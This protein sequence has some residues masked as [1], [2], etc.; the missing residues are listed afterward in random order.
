MSA[1]SILCEMTM[2][3][4]IAPDNELVAS[5]AKEGSEIAFQALVKRHVSLV[6]ATAFRQV[7]D[8]GMAEE[9]AQN[10]F[11]ALAQKAPRLAARE[12]LA[13]WLHRATIFEAKSRIR[14]ELRRRRHEDVVAE[15]AQLHCEKGAMTEDLLPVLDEGLLN[16][17]EGDRLALI[18]RFLDDRS[19]REVGDYFGVDEEAARKR[20]SRALD[21]LALFFQRQ[22]FAIPAGT[23]CAALMTSAA[24][25]AP[26]GLAVSI[27]QT[28]LLSGSTASG[29][30]LLLLNLMTLT[31]VQTA[32]ICLVLAATPLVLQR[33]AQAREENRKATLV[34]QLS[35]DQRQLNGLENNLDQ[36]NKQL[37]ASQSDSLNLG[38]NLG[39]LTNQ[40]SAKAARPVYAWDDQSP[41][42]RVPKQ[43]LKAIPIRAVQNQ[44]GQLTDQVKAALQFTPDEADKTQ[45]ALNQFLSQYY[46]EQARNMKSAAP[47]ANDLNGHQKEE[48]RVFDIKSISGYASELRKTLYGEFDSALGSERGQLIRQYLSDEIPPDDQFTGVNSATIVY[49]KDVRIFF[50]QPKPGDRQIMWGMQV[51]DCGTM[52]TGMEI[53][54][55]PDLY[56]SALND[57]ITIAKSNPVPVQDKEQ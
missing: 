54:E 17:R 5:Y 57:W 6:Y 9:I 14:T 51:K 41:L 24:Q 1:G 19:L 37:Q 39:T 31:K 42:L 49:N 7:G 38:A 10:V 23:G 28:A 32:A 15:V 13:G 45:A 29:I 56:R 21:K 55:I 44:R 25:A 46:T 3:S 4:P 16:L 12:T 34:R 36:L 26:A 43:F 20:V 18:L 30:S 8:R 47:N 2:V 22:G 11:I 40:L 33:Q 50:Y 53:D 35:E 52:Q 27:S 48:T